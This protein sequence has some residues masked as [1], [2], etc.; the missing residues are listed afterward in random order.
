MKYLELLPEYDEKYGVLH[1]QAIENAI[2]KHR[3][4]HSRAMD[5]VYKYRP[6]VVESAISFIENEFWQTTG[7]LELI[8]LQP[9]QKWWLELWFGYYTLTDD[10]LINET[11]LN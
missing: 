11:F 6:E 1:S 10:I 5:G 3:R 4:I 2:K 7:S 9:V 8:K